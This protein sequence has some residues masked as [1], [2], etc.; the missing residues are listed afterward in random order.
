M[1]ELIREALKKIAGNNNKILLTTGRVIS[2]SKETCDVE[3]SDGSPTYFEVRL[4]AVIDNKEDGFVI[5]PRVNSEVVI[6][7]IDKDNAILLSVAEPESVSI[8]IGKNKIEITED[9][10]SLTRENK[11]IEINE[12]IKLKNGTTTHELSST[13]NISTSNESLKSILSDL[14]TGIETLTVTTAGVPSLVPNNISIFT[15]IKARLNLLL[16]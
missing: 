6:G 8:S 4:R 1:S 2:V 5:A 13:H 3:P 10:V 11:I 14:I 9:K 16:S 12:N 15:S 7:L